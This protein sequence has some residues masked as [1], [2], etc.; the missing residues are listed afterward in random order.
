[1]LVPATEGYRLWAPTYD[2]GPNPMLALESRI[3]PNLLG[4]LVGKQVVDIACG[5]GRSM[6]QLIKLGASVIGL[7]ICAEMLVQAQRKPTLRSSLIQADAS[8]LPLTHSISDL[9]LCSFAAGYIPDLDRAM[10]E[11][12]RITKRMGKV[13]LCDLHPAAHAAGW[14]RSFRSNNTVFEIENRAYSLDHISSC[15]Q[16]LGL[17]LATRVEAS[18]GPPERALFQASGK[19]AVYAQA[20]SIPAICINVWSRS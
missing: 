7:D 16:R 14:T 18:F 5:T 3:L 20:S 9:T 1:M 8:N 10:L 13:I 4:P 15:A 17:K 19:E 6:L 2:A 12:A 11:M